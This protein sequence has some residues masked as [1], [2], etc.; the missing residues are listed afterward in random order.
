MR[1]ARQLCVFALLVSVGRADEPSPYELARTI[2][3][4]SPDAGDSF[5]TYT[6]G[7]LSNGNLVVG[8]YGDDTEGTDAGAVHV[9]NPL[10]GAVVRTLYSPN[11]AAGDQFGI[12]VAARGNL[13]LAGATG[14]DT[15]A[16]GAGA[17]YLFDADTGAHL[18]T[19]LPAGASTGAFGGFPV[20]FGADWT[21]DGIPELVMGAYPDAAAGVAGAGRVFVF[22]G[23]TG[24]VHRVYEN[25]EPG[26]NDLFGTHLAVDGNHLL[27]GAAWDS[28]DDILRPGSAYLYDATT[29]SLL[30]TFRDP[31]PATNDHFGEW[32]ALAGGRAIIAAH[33]DEAEG[34][35][36]GAAYVYD[37]ATGSLLHTLAPPAPADGDDFGYGLAVRGDLIILG[38]SRD[39]DVG[40]DA[41]AAYVFDATTGALVC[42]LRSPNPVPGGSFGLGVGF[43]GDGIVVG[44]SGG[45]GGAGAV[46]VFAPSYEIPRF[47]TGDLFVFDASAAAK[48]AGAVPPYWPFWRFDAPSPD[49]VPL[50]GNCDISGLGFAFDSDGNLYVGKGG[51]TGTLE[52]YDRNF[53]KLGEA[54]KI[55]GQL[56]AHPAFRR[57]GQLVA[58]HP[59][60]QPALLLVYDVSDPSNAQ[61]ARSEEI[62]FTADGGGQGL[63]VQRDGRVWIG[64]SSAL[65][66]LD[67]DASGAIVGAQSFALAVNPAALC[68]Q[69][70]TGRLIIGAAN[71]LVLVDPADPTTTLATIT[72]LSPVAA[73]TPGQM[74]FDSAG[75]LFVGCGNEDGG[76]GGDADIVA[77]A[78]ASLDGLAGTHTAA[79]LGAVAH[80]FTGMDGG[81]CLAFKPEGKERDPFTVDAGENLSILSKD[82]GATVLAATVTSNP[83]EETLDFVRWILDGT[84]VG[85]A[86]SL[87]LSLLPPLGIGDH[88]FT[89]EADGCMLTARDAVVVTVENSPPTAAPSG[90]G[91]FALGD[92]FAVGGEVADFDGEELGYEW[93]RGTLVLASGTVSTAAG[94]APVPLPA[95]MLDTGDLGIGVHLLELAIDDGVNE[96]VVAAMT[97]EVFQADTTAPTLSPEARPSI[98]WPPNGRLRKVVVHANAVDD[99]QG[100]VQLAVSVE[101]RDASGRPARESGGHDDPDEEDEHDAEEDGHDDD[102]ACR[103]HRGPA[104]RILSVDSATGII[105]LKLRAARRRGVGLVYTIT[106]TAT[107]ASGNSSSSAV[108]VHAPHRRGGRR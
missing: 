74:A 88:V 62:P 7:E 108:E 102:C 40:A 66:R 54:A 43:V 82:Q 44:E 52:V 39:D 67:L 76:A 73:N 86:F 46:H 69:P 101:C 71:S 10:T 18:L 15:E 45:A 28:Y 92:S 77:F 79:S 30:R 96:E 3:N 31:T 99:S 107:D 50:G 89:F 55:T 72:D 57:D 47:E 33:I 90:G 100:P 13:V 63:A 29:G 20:A 34:F 41:G 1:I 23:A 53:Q 103:F 83:L 87:D 4:P 60:S 35:R 9:I 14:D 56:P 16:P 104:Y 51:K 106:I 64:A 95:T 27:I 36:S 5:G 26:T 21:A 61:L 65:V 24:A 68:F 97:V 42:T 80:H 37:T 17:A 84:Q 91:V 48:T 8:A 93:R 58:V 19:L 25:P 49:Q 81:V 22:D 59:T 94:G 98:L 11:A 2:P 70:S 38:A 75:N 78:A 6:I 85:D 32:V 105:K 12:T